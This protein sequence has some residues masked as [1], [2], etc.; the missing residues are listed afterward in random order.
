MAF[1]TTGE[2]Y[3]VIFH[4]T[5]DASWSALSTFPTLPAPLVDVIVN[6]TSVLVYV[7]DSSAGQ[8]AFPGGQT[9]GV[10][11]ALLSSSSAALSKLETSAVD[12][13]SWINVKDSSGGW[14]IY[15]VGAGV[16]RQFTTPEQTDLQAF[17]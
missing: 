1:K 8:I 5:N 12:G 9:D 17:L 6:G 13:Y 7:V 15:D 10:D 16:I 14:W 3:E 2:F 11:D 4:Q